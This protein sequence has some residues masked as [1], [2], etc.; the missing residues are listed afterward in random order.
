VAGQ[1][2]CSQM[3]SRSIGSKNGSTP[4][5]RLAKPQGLRNN[6]LLLKEWVNFQRDVLVPPVL[7]LLP[8]LTLLSRGLPGGGIGGDRKQKFSVS[9]PT[10]P[11]CRCSAGLM[12][13]GIS[14]IGPSDMHTAPSPPRRPINTTPREIRK[15]RHPKK[16]LGAICNWGWGRFARPVFCPLFPPLKNRFFSVF[17]PNPG[18]TRR[19]LNWPITWT[20]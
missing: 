20:D 9:A 15:I 11:I 19:Q 18:Q 7:P 16:G 4:D 10:D 13:E 17:A 2:G 12:M 3:G 8:R 5:P 14:S 1:S 6:R